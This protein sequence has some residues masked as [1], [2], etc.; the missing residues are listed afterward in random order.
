[1]QQSVAKG[2]F[3]SKCVCACVFLYMQYRLRMIKIGHQTVAKCLKWD[4]LFNGTMLEFHVK[5][6]IYIILYSV[7]NI[8]SQLDHYGLGFHKFPGDL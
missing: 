7:Y 3:C 8:Y 1:M 2:T 6:Y 4:F 5:V